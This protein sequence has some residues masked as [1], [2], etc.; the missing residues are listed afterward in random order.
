MVLNQ[1]FKL[2]SGRTT[3]IK[4]AGRY[5]IYACLVYLTAEFIKWSVAID[6]GEVKFSEY[7]FVEYAQSILLLLSSIV[8][9]TFYLS[10]S[11]QAYKNIL[12]LLAGL[13][14]VALIREQDIYFE[15]FL[16]H[17]VWPI[18]VL[19]II[20]IVAYK[21]FKSR[22]E[23]WAEVTLYVKTKSYAFFT[24]GTLTIFIF[25]R[26]FGR[27]KFWE[28]TMG[29]RYFRSVK[30]VAEE[31]LELYGYL[32]FLCAIVELIIL[33]KEKNLLARNSN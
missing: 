15:Q 26:L 24:F 27:T 1:R 10:K 5:L 23:L 17:G 4:E 11:S 25:S 16:G 22:K 19:V 31:S 32:F 9:F 30:N 6:E 21:A 2:P 8:S 3:V 14:S 29:D 13:S 20:C 33:I 28:A 18:P 12:L 7:S